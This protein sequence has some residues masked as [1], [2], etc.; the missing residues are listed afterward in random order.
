MPPQRQAR[1]ILTSDPGSPAPGGQALIRLFTPAAIRKLVGNVRCQVVP[2]GGTADRSKGFIMQIESSVDTA[3]NV[4]DH[5]SNSKNPF[6]CVIVTASSRKQMTSGIPI[7]GKHTSQLRLFS[8]QIV[9]DQL[10]AYSLPTRALK[11][12]A[13][14]AVRP[15]PNPRPVFSAVRLHTRTH[16]PRFD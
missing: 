16:T 7:L 8:S 5:A 3:S 13:A 2:E 14:A 6:T 1:L 15:S 4:V 9:C 11:D 12:P 10:I